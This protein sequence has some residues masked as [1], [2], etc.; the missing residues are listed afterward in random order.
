MNTPRTD[1]PNRSGEAPQGDS[2][3]PTSG[4]GNGTRGDLNRS[5]SNSLVMG[6]LQDFGRAPYQ[7]RSQEADSYFIKVL[8]RRGERVLWGKDLERALSASATQPK[9]GDQVGARRTGRDAVT[10]LAKERDAEGRV[11]SQ[12]EQH[13]HRQR[14]VVEKVQFFA[15]RAKLAHRVRD[16]QADIRQTVKAHPELMSTFISLR[17][18]QDLAERRIANPRDRERFLSLVREAMAGSIKSG[19][20]LPLVRLKN[21][22]RTIPK[23]PSV[24]GP[25][26]SNRD[27]DVPTR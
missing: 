8:T 25:T 22:A 12:S 18:A 3:A 2:G 24:A 23:T 14:W 17:G 27:R 26:N 15:E 6:R 20:P 11:V 10:I 4:R 16:E 19:E 7:F 21:V 1:G 13:A 5:R 9:R